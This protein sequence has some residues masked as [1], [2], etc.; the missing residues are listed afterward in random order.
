[1]AGGAVGEVEALLQAEGSVGPPFGQAVAAGVR[2]P[3]GHRMGRRRADP[4]HLLRAAD[5]V[6]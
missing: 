4:G 3:V 5:R 6:Q 1:M 2:H